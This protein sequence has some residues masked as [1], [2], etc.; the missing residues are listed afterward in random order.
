MKNLEKEWKHLYTALP[1]G[2]EVLWVCVTCGAVIKDRI[3]HILFH[4]EQVKH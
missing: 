2:G 1:L 4:Q 3:L